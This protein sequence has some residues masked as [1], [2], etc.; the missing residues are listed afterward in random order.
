MYLH[1]PI[2]YPVS[3][4]ESIKNLEQLW[5]IKKFIRVLR[6][7]STII[8]WILAE[9]SRLYHSNENFLLQKYYASNLK[10]YSAAKAVILLHDILLLEAARKKISYVISTSR[11][12]DTSYTLPKILQSIGWS[13]MGYQAVAHVPTVLRERETSRDG[14]SGSWR[15][16]GRGV[17]GK[18]SVRTRVP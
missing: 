7:D 8:A 18:V 4:E 1:W 3:R 10:G 17:L 15:S 12:D 6:R 13:R 2:N 5:K 11:F 16:L 9:E 14:R